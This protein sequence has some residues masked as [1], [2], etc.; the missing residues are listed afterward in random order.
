MAR[1]EI[2]LIGLTK[3]F[4]EVVAGGDESNAIV[5]A[6]DAVNLMTAHAAKGLEFPVVFTVNLQRG[7]GGAVEYRCC[8]APG[9]GRR[10]RRR[11]N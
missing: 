7:S 2:R 11:R 4:A 9:R 5:D 8:P 6:I 3:R 10:C 1:G